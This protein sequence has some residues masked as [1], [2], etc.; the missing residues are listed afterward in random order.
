MFLQNVLI[1][2]GFVTDWDAVMGFCKIYTI[3][4]YCEV[5]VNAIF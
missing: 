1:C 2:Y 5:S 3:R 4:V